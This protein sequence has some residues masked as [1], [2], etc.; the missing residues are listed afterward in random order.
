MSVG[1][2]QI[3]EFFF[4]FFTYSSLSSRTSALQVDVDPRFGALSKW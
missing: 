3:G 1:Q 2:R 4:F